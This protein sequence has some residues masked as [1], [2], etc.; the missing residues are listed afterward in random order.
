M[1]SFSFTGSSKKTYNYSHIPEAGFN[2]IPRQ[3]G[4]YVIASGEHMRPTP[5]LIRAC[6]SVRKALLDEGDRL[7]ASEKHGAIALYVHFDVD[8]D[9]DSRQ[10]EVDDLI[11]NYHPPMNKKG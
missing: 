7:A 3:P 8:G 1:V 2:N 11:S 9:P 10:R 4:N 5:I 6:H